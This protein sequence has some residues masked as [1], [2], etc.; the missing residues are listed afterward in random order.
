VSLAG[1]AGEPRRARALLR[2][3]YGLCDLLV[4]LPLAWL[5]R[6][7][8]LP[9]AALT[10]WAWNPWIALEFAGAGH[11]DSGAILCTLGAL[12]C[13]P[14]H[15]R[16]SPGRSAAALAL[17]ATGA[18]LKLLPLAL[19]PFVLRRVHRP[20]LGL[21][22]FLVVLVLGV[23]PL[24]FLSGR[25]P[26][27]GG[28]SE[29]AFRWESFSL[30]YRWIEPLFAR[31]FTFDERWSDPRWLAR[32][33]VLVLWLALALR[34]WRRRHAP[35][36]AAAGLLG[37][38]LMLTPTLHPWYLGWIVPFLALRPALAW[39]ALVAAAPLLY[40]PLVRWRGEHV[41]VEPAWLWPALAGPFWALAA[42]EL[43][44]SRRAARP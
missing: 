1:G 42:L 20:L 25:P 31:V 11:L 39:S 19:V 33:L 28:L 18:G 6:A 30:L 13:L 12:A 40:W 29:Y 22:G 2:A 27:L 32:E 9:L 23:L 10:A 35:V 38:F 24:A 36:R 16:A 21:L 3:F 17:L 34:A 4:C 7:R 37:A 41:W 14:V 5:L 26:R 44:R 15:G 8:R 43:V